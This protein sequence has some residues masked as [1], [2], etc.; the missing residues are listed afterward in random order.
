MSSSSSFPLALKVFF[1]SLVAGVGG[2]YGAFKLAVFLV[3]KYWKGE[4]VEPISLLI[5][6]I[7]ALVLGVCSA[8]TAGVLAGRVT[9][10]A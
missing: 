6:L 4:N 1:F 8:V 2:G 3:L 7:A 5:G 9:R 10:S